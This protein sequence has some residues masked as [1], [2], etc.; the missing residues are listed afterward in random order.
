MM[1]CRWRTR[2]GVGSVRQM[3]DDSVEIT[4]TQSYTPYGD[5]LTGDGTATTGYAFTRDV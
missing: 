2:R 5:V 1:H 4:L 3:T